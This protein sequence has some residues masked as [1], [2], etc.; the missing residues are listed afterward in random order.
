M[1]TTLRCS[2]ETASWS[3]TSVVKPGSPDILIPETK[4]CRINNFAYCESLWKQQGG[5]FTFQQ[6]CSER[7][8][9]TQNHWFKMY[10][11]NSVCCLTVLGLM[12][13]KCVLKVEG[14]Q[15]RDR[16]IKETKLYY[17]LRYKVLN[18]K[19]ISWTSNT[20]MRI[21][22]WD[23]NTRMRW[24]CRD[25]MRIQG[26]DKNT[27]MGFKYWMRIQGWEYKDKNIRMGWKYKDEMRI[28]GWKYKDKNTKK[29]IQGW[30]E[31]TRMGW[32]YKYT[33]RQ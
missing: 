5:R 9:Q 6:K 24:E 14:D 22:G 10:L 19:F 12:K 13:R 28:Q 3:A 27:R 18:Q 4:N 11:C 20:R 33:A 26:W 7:K 17:Y 8:I 29:R 31:S 21:Q 2:A 1:A 30:D 32:K 16:V 25:G 15:F 23:E